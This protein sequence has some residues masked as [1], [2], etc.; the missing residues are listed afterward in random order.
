MELAGGGAVL[1][2]LMLGAIAVFV[3]DR[4]FNWAAVFALFAAALSYFGFINGSHLALNASPAVSAAYFMAFLLFSF[5]S[6]RQLKDGKGISWAP[7]DNN[8]ES[9]VHP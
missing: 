5:L 3:I 7:I 2:G 4:R 6:W 9:L 8:E 1:A